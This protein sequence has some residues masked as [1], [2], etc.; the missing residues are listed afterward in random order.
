MPI[1][2]F[3]DRHA[4][5]RL[6]L[7]I[8]IDKRQAKP[9][10]QALAYRCLPRP[11]HADERDHAPADRGPEKRTIGRR[12]IRALARSAAPGRPMNVA[13]A[14]QPFIPRPAAARAAGRRFI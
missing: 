9:R 12:R 10:R 6:D 1:E 5:R 7:G 11:H 2:D 3:R 4:G 13:V 8:R 14:R